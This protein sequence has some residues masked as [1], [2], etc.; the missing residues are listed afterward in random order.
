MNERSILTAPMER[1]NKVRV[2]D[3]VWPVKEAQ[4]NV[5]KGFGK[6][7]LRCRAWGG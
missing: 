7:D 6:C 4:K 3:V 2:I 1:N 5:D